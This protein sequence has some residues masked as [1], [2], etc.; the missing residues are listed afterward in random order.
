MYAHGYQTKGSPTGLNTAQEVAYF[1]DAFVKAGYA[2][3]R[4]AYRQQGWALTEGVED[5]EALR[6]YFVQKYGQPDST[7]ITGHSMGGMITVATIEKY[8][9]YYQAGMPMCPNTGRVYELMKTR[10]FDLLVTFDALFPNTLPPLSELALGNA[11]SLAQV[12]SQKNGQIEPSAAYINKLKADS[13]KAR[14]FAERYDIKPADLAW[15]IP[16]YAVILADISQKAGGNPFDNTNTVYGG[17]GDNVAVNAKAVRLTETPGA[18]RYLEKD[19]AFTGQLSKPLL[20]LHTTYDQLI[21]SNYATGYED[22]ARQAGKE[23]L[24]V[25][26]YTNSQGHCVFTPQETAN[27]FNQLR[28]WA[29]TGTK[30]VAGELKP[31]NGLVS[32]K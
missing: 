11:N 14:Q 13:A 2:L 31:A 22:L 20:V 26:K 23:Q 7:F 9:Q 18:R 3:A 8:P 16:F 1:Q 32:G 27:A 28:R 15:V 19:G 12:F 10:V 5:T 4:S 21:P 24:F 25:V 17:F 30:P 29:K 6:K